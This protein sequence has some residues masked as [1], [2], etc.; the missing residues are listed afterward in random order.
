[1][2]SFVSR[3]FFIAGFVVF[4]LASVAC[5]GSK[6]PAQAPTNEAS[7]APRVGSS[8]PDPSKDGAGTASTAGSKDATP[9]P[10]ASSSADNGSDI[11]PPFPSS[12][13]GKD[14]GD[15]GDKS[16]D[17]TAEKDNAAAGGSS[18]T[19]EQAPPKKKAAKSSGG[20][21]KTGGKGKKKG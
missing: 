9:S 4:G 2:H 21:K 11:V 7:E 19:K 18:D 8:T 1:M 13:P 6:K 20:A 3:S 5:G 12:G 16:A 15:K 14:K 17:K 10:A